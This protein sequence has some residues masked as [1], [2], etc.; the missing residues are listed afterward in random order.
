MIQTP[1]IFSF[2]APVNNPIGLISVPHAGL[3]LPKDLKEYLID[4]HSKLNCDVDFEVDKLIDIQKLTKAGIGV[5]VAHIHRTGVDLNRSRD[6]ALLNWKENTHGQ[7][8]VIKSPTHSEKLLAKY[9]DPYYHFLKSSIEQL[10]ILNPKE[11]SVVDLHSMPS[12]PTAYHLKQKPGQSIERPDFCVS[13][14]N[15]KTCSVEFIQFAQNQFKQ[16]KYF[17]QLNDPYIGGNLTTFIDQFRT[18]NI[19]IEINRK[20]YMD[21]KKQ[22]LIEEKVNE[23]KPNLTQV[24]INLFEKFK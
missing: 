13:D 4:D 23:L 2:F 19:Q 6:L 7:T 14:Q 24:L 10:Q 5:L 21:E 22:I 12:T 15:G 1:D 16:L 11:I 20:L 8:I 3:E 9:Y 17:S 18:N